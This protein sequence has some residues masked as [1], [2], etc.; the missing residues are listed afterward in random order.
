MKKPMSVMNLSTTTIS[1][2][3][4]KGY[5]CYL[6]SY[7]SELIIT[8]SEKPIITLSDTYTT[9]KSHM[10]SFTESISNK[11]KDVNEE[12]KKSSEDEI[13]T[14]KSNKQ[15]LGKIDLIGRFSI[16]ISKEHFNNNETVYKYYKIARR[17]YEKLISRMEETV[18]IAV[19]II[20]S[21][22]NNEYNR[23][24]SK[25]LNV[26]EV[27][28]V[29]RLYEFSIYRDYALFGIEYNLYNYPYLLS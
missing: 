1:N 11:V 3:C 16:E 23:Q 6:P 26:K 9:L 14:L 12:D 25:V 28:K 8:E 21:I 7:N 5:D 15:I 24:K 17:K 2:K 18:K 29:L 10:Q 19:E 22:L 13:I 27:Y 20:L 4:Y